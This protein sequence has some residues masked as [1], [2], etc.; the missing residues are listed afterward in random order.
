M[1]MEKIDMLLID[2]ALNAT[3]PD[4]AALVDAF[5]EKDS[6]ARIRLDNFRS[7]AGAAK[8]AIAGDTELPP[9][10]RTLA[11][12][13]GP[14]VGPRHR[15][16]P[17]RAQR[18]ALW[19]TGLAAC[20]AISFFAGTLARFSIDS[21][22]TVALIPAPPARIDPEKNAPPRASP[23]CRSFGRF[24]TCRRVP[25]KTV[26]VPKIPV[27]IGQLSYLTPGSVLP[28]LE[29]KHDCTN[30][31]SHC[32]FGGRCRA[33]W[34]HSRPRCLVARWHPGRHHRLRWPASLQRRRRDLS[35]LLV[36]ECST[37][38]WMPDGKKVVVIRKVQLATWK[39]FHAVLPDYAV[40]LHDTVR[41]ELL[42]YTGD[43]S[44][45]VASIAEKLHVDE[46]QITP[47][48]LQLR[49][50]EA[51]A[52]QPLLG[53]R[54]KELS[55]LSCEASVGQVLDLSDG[56]AKPEK[57]LICSTQSLGELVGLRR[58]AHRKNRRFRDCSEK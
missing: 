14:L 7:T 26:P 5:V 4:V 19:A 15:L 21:P 24:P 36:P 44:K 39:E 12:L 16:T 31:Y 27:P 10:P 53:D 3:P 38:G 22:H 9:L 47:A 42:A 50:T 45:L 57:P 18:V 32:C 20:M 58:F 6:E 52:L 40:K 43:A 17:S 56:K 49:N 1:D 41:K 11:C 51:V 48:L 54:W 35:P 33:W 2:H 30:L 34:M 13:A 25:R 8:R 55:N 29:D 46:D 23:P 28:D 37:V